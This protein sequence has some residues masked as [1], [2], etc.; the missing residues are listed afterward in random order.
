MS[1]SKT[2]N[3]FF[4]AWLSVFLLFNTSALFAQKI[5]A[6]GEQLAGFGFDDT[7]SAEPILEYQQ[8][9]A[10]LSPID[11]KP[12][13]RVFGDGRVLVHHPAYMKKAGDFEMRLSD[14]E[15]VRLL[16]D[17]S[18]NGIMDF[19][20]KKVKEKIK[21]HEEK[22]KAKGQFYEVSDTLETMVNVK[23]DE[24][25]KDKKAKNI[26]SFS[27]QFKWKNLEQDAARHKDALEITKANKSIQGLNQMMHDPR[28]INQR[29]R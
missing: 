8:N 5:I 25:Q 16:R 12:S 15:L 26:K 28:L 24:Y 17:L 6:S 13:L 10:M 18:S 27:T 19:D 29:L 1:K 23:L 4:T 11:D 20:A 22:L 7:A 3:Y 14:A 21:V 2:I 9:I